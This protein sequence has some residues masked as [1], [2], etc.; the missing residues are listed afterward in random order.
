MQMK[1][2]L[3]LQNLEQSLWPLREKLAEHEIYRHIR[4]ISEV[5][6][7]MEHHVFAVWDF[8]SLLKALQRDLTCVAIP[9]VPQGNRLSRR[10]IN[11]IVLEEES[12]ADGA[13]GYL[14]H[15]ELYRAAMAQCGADLSSIDGFLAS[16]RNG[17]NA[18]TALHR[19]GAPK[20]AESF[21]K[22]TMRIVKRGSIH[23]IAAAF[24]LG[25]EDIIPQ[26]FTPLVANLEHQ[27]PGQL[28]LFQNYLQR[29]IRLDEERHTPMA[30]QMLM[31]LC[32]DDSVKWQEAQ[33]TALTALL[34]RIELWEG[35]VE[36]V[37]ATKRAGKVARPFNGGLRGA[38]F[39][40]N[41]AD[42]PGCGGE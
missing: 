9:W 29:H 20:A 19:A 10:L 21:V 34:A 40:F 27:F 3:S 30:L 13:G 31:E 18:A 14:S 12:D 8:M 24:T 33:E 28:T 16:I 5:H 39:T 11:E 2:T 26:M 1:P 6:I 4:N 7:F 37:A 25:R 38:P 36:Q 23:A 32:G 22:T 17:D 42:Q 15:F 35:V 41:S